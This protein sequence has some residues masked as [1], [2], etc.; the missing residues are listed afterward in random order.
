MMR[1]KKSKTSYSFLDLVK[2]RRW[3]QLRASKV[4]ARNGE[5]STINSLG[6]R[7]AGIILGDCP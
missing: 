4:L 7:E 1:W 6:D 2:K 5:R 3:G